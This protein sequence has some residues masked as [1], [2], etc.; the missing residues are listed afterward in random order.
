MF[1]D[2]EVWIE[3]VALEYAPVLAARVSRAQ[4][5]MSTYTYSAIR[6]ESGVVYPSGIVHPTTFLF[7]RL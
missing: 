4:V 3:S 6:L 7:A 1:K 2:E 5:L